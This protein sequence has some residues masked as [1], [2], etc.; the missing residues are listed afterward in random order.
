MF[1]YAQSD[2]GSDYVQVSLNQNKAT[3]IPMLTAVTFENVPD[4]DPECAVCQRR[5]DNHVHVHD[6]DINLN[7]PYQINL[8]TGTIITPINQSHKQH[9]QY[10]QSFEQPQAFPQIALP[11]RRANIDLQR[12]PMIFSQ[13]PPVRSAIARPV[14]I[15]SQPQPVYVE[16]QNPNL[17]QRVQMTPVQVSSVPQQI[18]TQVARSVKVVPTAPVV[19]KMV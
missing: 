7:N 4:F 12:T 8:P 14:M 16:S 18:V 11:N 13:I 1:Y 3:S 2:D 15:Q 17:M 19:Y 10:I 6:N 5:L 9:A